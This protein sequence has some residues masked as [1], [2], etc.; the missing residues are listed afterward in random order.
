MELAPPTG[1]NGWEPQGF[2]GIQLKGEHEVD[3]TKEE[4][5]TANSSFHPAGTVQ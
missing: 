2:V 4:E 1:S 5:E 3:P